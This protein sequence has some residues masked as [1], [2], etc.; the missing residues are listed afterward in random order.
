MY[1]VLLRGL[2]PV[3]VDVLRHDLGRSDTG[4]DAPLGPDAGD[5]RQHAVQDSP[6]RQLGVIDRFDDFLGICVM[7]SGG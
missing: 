3:A 6:C 5:V 7:E 2:F 4:Q 1:E